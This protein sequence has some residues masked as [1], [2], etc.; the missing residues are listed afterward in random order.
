MMHARH[1]PA[2]VSMEKSKEILRHGE[3]HGK[4]LTKKQKGFFG[5]RAGGQPVKRG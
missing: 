4:A 2:Q 5:A 3:V 1:K